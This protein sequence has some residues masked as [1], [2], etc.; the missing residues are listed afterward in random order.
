MSRT[1]QFFCF[2]HQGKADAYIRALEARGWKQSTSIALARFVLA[3]ADV[4][5]RQR[6]LAEAARRRKKIFLYPHAARPNI[7]W[8]FPGTSY[9]SFVTAHF[10]VSEGHIQ[11][12]KAYGNPYP[13]HAVGW[14]LCPIL[15]FRARREIRNVLFGPIHP[16]SNGF[17][18]RLDRQ[19][20]REAFERVRSLASEG[21]ALTVRHL[22][23]IK[24]NGLWRAGGVTYVEG[25]RDQSYAEI[26][27]ADLVVSHQTFAHLAI[28]RGVPTLMMGE[29]H[30]PRWGGSE[31]ALQMVRSWDRYRDLLAYPLDIL[32]EED[33]QALATRAT[34]CDC[35][36]EDW[37][38]R[39]IGTPFDGDR[40]VDLVESYL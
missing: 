18:C 12:M 8:D 27:Q 19:L 15:P 13:L 34:G 2:N 5:G 36:I 35:E 3:D 40:F 10:V 38:E 7:F 22:H 4:R 37:R 20:N 23:D 14:H 25:S 31:E 16:N 28:A 11:I 32:A 29:W 39:L 9:S 33:T 21:V 6:Q 24:T 1:R 30:P 26:D 17:L